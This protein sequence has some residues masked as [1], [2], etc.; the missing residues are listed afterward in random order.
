MTEQND[1]TAPLM[2]ER[3]EDLGE[4]CPPD[5][6]LIADL[7]D[8]LEAWRAACPNAR[9]KFAYGSAYEG[10]L[11]IYWTEPETPEEVTER[12]ETRK[13]WEHEQA[14]KR[15]V[16]EALTQEQREALGY[17]YWRIA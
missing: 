3:E 16:L 14:Q 15:T 10:E 13:R 6:W 12:I 1:E 8:M 11:N 9:I 2:V 5:G 17:G 4:Y 7:M